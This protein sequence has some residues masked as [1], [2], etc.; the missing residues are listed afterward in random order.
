M[1]MR[2]RHVEKERNHMMT[3]EK[4]NRVLILTE[5]QLIFYGK[6]T[7]LANDLDSVLLGEKFSI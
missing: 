3:M 4:S 7:A 1:A 6:H 2:F 5:F